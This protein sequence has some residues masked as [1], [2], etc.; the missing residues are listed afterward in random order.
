MFRS[1][2]HFPFQ[3][4]NLIE[5][6]P[7]PAQNV[8]TCRAARATSAA[9]TYFTEVE[10]GEA[11]FVDGGFGAANS[12]TQ[13]VFQEVRQMSGNNEH[14]IAMT[15]SIGTGQ[16]RDGLNINGHQFLSKLGA[17]LRWT[18]HVI[19]DSEVTHRAMDLFHSTSAR[20]G[21]YHR[22]NVDSGLEDV[23][24]GEWKEAWS[25][26]GVQCVTLDK[27]GEA[28]RDYLNKPEV[29]SRLRVI[30]EILV[31]SRRARSESPEWIN[32][33][34]GY[35]YHCTIDDCL[36]RNTRHVTVGG[37]KQHII[38]GHRRGNVT[39]EEIEALRLLV[40]RGKI[41]PSE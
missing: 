5:L 21:K 19:T 31:E 24:L 4:S 33:A 25:A 16:P 3:N 13:Y 34:T 29:Q 2:Q 30:A 28:T 40:E 26:T 12:P 14:A 22:L 7:G 35:Q 15:V 18:T 9:P 32:F 1:Y 10:I 6:N 39:I 36:D 11:T 23:K 8:P 37:L 20:Q 17:Y 27:I 41:P 38:T